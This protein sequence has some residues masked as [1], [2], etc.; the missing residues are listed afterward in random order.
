MTYKRIDQI[1]AVITESPIPHIK[2]DVLNESLEKSGLDRDKFSQYFGVQTC[3]Q[4]G[5]YP[6]DVESVLERMMSGKLIGTQLM[7]D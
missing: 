2:F 6:W 7:V 3:Y 1:G 4:G 5:L